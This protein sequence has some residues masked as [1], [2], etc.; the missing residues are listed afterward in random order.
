MKKYLV[1]A[2]IALGSVLISCSNDDNE[3]L[4]TPQIETESQEFDYTLSQK[5]GDSTVMTD[6]ETG[7]QGG[8]NPIKP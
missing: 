2:F 1:V 5:E 8:N 3:A 6:G 7:G 4:S